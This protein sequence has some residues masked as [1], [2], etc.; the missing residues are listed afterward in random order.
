[1]FGFV[2]KALS[3]FKFYISDRKQSVKFKNTQSDSR[4]LA[5]G[6]PQGS[7]Q[8]PLLFTLYTTLIS[9]IMLSYMYIKHH[10]YDDDTQIY[11]N[12]TPGNNTCPSDSVKNLG[13]VFDSK[14]SFSKN[15]SAVCS[16][17]YYHIR[18]FTRIQHH[19]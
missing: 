18:D 8:C 11:I 17:C 4:P 15:V 10:L 9:K 7:V 3:C 2:D 6:V 1:M 5:F 16:S 12:I 13:V 14:F 19:F